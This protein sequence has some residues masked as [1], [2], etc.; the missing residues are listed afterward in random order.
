MRSAP[1]SPEVDIIL[2]TSEI[3]HTL[4]SNPQWAVG[5]YALWCAFKK[6]IGGER[7]NY[8]EIAQSAC[9]AEL[10]ILFC[11]ELIINY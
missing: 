11:A 6:L 3:Y 7:V 1:V 8:L 2:H 5:N 9:I 4:H 10:T